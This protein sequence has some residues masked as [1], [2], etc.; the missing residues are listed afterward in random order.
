MAKP[1][2]LFPPVDSL[3]VHF[4]GN[5]WC[6]DEGSPGD[7]S[8]VISKFCLYL[9]R[10]AFGQ[11]VEITADP[12]ILPKK[13]RYT[14]LNGSTAWSVFAGFMAIILFFVTIIGF[15]AFW[16]SKTCERDWDDWGRSLRIEWL[17]ANPTA[18]AS[19]ELNDLVRHVAENLT[20]YKWMVSDETGLMQHDGFKQAVL[21]CIQNT[22]WAEGA[23]PLPASIQDP[24][25]LEFVKWAENPVY[26]ITR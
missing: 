21:Y 13:E 4:S 18:P 11:E 17:K 9:F 2:V 6:D 23:P 12:S 3:W 25:F 16:Y 7:A 20:A 19:Q 1:I 8:E 15:I 5:T 24:K 26:Q 22:A 10:Q 14:E